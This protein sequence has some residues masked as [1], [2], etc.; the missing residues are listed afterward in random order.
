MS[1]CIKQAMNK[2]EKVK[3]GELSALDVATELYELQKSISELYGEL[4]DLIIEERSRYDSKER[5]VKNGYEISIVTSQRYSCKGDEHWES[6]NQAR[7]NREAL[8]KKAYSMSKKNKVLTDPDTGEVV[9][10]AEVK[11]STYPKLTFI[12]M[13]L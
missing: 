4:K 8:M 1:E 7:K 9:P 12:G 13:E 10:P 6:L 3:Q 2:V 11:T 5:V